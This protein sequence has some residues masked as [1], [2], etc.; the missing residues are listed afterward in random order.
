[1]YG[2][3]QSNGYCA[4]LP[5]GG[6]VSRKSRVEIQMQKD[7]LRKSGFS[8]LQEFFRQGK[9]V[10]TIFSHAKH[11]EDRIRI[12]TFSSGGEVAAAEKAALHAAL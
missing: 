7:H 12:F 9:M 11:F 5:C 3:N 6:S 10:E 1:M 8:R 2:R 4:A